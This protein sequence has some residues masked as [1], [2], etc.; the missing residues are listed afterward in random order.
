MKIQLRPFTLLL[1]LCLVAG[2]FDPPQTPPEPATPQ[3]VAAAKPTEVQQFDPAAG[4]TIVDPTR[5]ITDPITGPLVALQNAR[6]KIPQLAIQH[7]IN[8]F[9]AS[10]GRY[11]A[12]LEEFMS[13]IIQENRIN[14][15]QLA[16]GL[17]WEYD[18]DAHQLVV[19][20]SPAKP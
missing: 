11:P 6:E 2:C 3:P 4:K 5:P 8:L 13:R 9:H 18:V 19:V 7:A 15:P 1:C 17:T 10:E 16:Q 20:Q 12:S 14:L